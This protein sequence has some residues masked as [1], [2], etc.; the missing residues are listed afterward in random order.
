MEE[1]GDEHNNEHVYKMQRQLKEMMY[2]VGVEGAVPHTLE[3]PHG[4]G[5]AYIR[6][7]FQ[8]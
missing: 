2:S 6:G 1:R 7:G 3:R 5:E 8:R 4:Q